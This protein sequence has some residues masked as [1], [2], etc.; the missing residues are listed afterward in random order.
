MV[1]STTGVEG[2]SCWA[3]GAAVRSRVTTWPAMGFGASSPSRSREVPSRSS[4]P[5]CPTTT[6]EQPRLWTSAFSAAPAGLSETA[7]TSV[8]SSS[9]TPIT[10]VASASAASVGASAPNSATAVGP[11]EVG[12]RAN[13]PVASHTWGSLF[14]TTI[15]GS[16]PNDTTDLLSSLP[17]SG[18]TVRASIFIT[19]AWMVGCLLSG[20]T[21]V[22]ASA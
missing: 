2:K 20:R 21:L 22:S 12:P 16:T 6:C 11:G 4:R 1:G 9:P 3:A 5:L 19:R 15:L 10:T 13:E 17:A 14:C 8:P 7:T 18:L